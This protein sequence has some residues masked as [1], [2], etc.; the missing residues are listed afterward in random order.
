MPKDAWLENSQ[1][2][3]WGGVSI[4]FVWGI[5]R[6]FCKVVFEDLKSLPK[7]LFLPSG[8]SRALRLAVGHGTVSL[9][10]I[11]KLSLTPRAATHEWAMTK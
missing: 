4:G 1:R 8:V 10:C 5:Y 3:V 6:L 2:A 7:E 9:P 11:M